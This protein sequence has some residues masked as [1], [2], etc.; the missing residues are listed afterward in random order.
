MGKTAYGEFKFS[1]PTDRASIPGYAHGG[2]ITKGEA[3]MGKV[4]SE[5][6]SGD[7]HSGSK[8]GPVVKNPKQAIAIAMSEKKAAGYAKGGKAKSEPKAMVKKEVALL[9]KAGAPTKMI[10]HEEAEMP[11]GMPAAPMSP[12][13]AVAR[14]P[15]A[16]PGMMKKGGEVEGGKADMAQDKA[17]IKKAFKQHDAQEHKGGKGTSLKLK[18]GGP[19]SEDRMRVGRNLSRAANQ[20][21]G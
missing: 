12:L 16:A 13:A 20:K 3:K 5:F 17:M 6:K 4:M 11:E 2:K 15:M 1:K 10:R 21:T 7:L 9:R 8:S 18:K 19:T 14:P